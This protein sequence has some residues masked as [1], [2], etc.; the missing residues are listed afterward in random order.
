MHGIRRRKAHKATPTRKTFELRLASHPRNV[1]RV[2]AFLL[3]VNRQARLD[4]GTMYRLLVACTEAVNNAI[5]HGN[6]ADPEKVV[7]VT[8]RLAR[9]CLTLRVKDQ[10]P[11]FD[12][13][14]LPS[15]LEEQNLMRESGR[16]VFLMRSLM[17]EVRFERL[18]RGSVVQM[19]ICLER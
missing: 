6:K 18:K 9:R 13:S 3:K 11:G 1:G 8:C 16:G 5:L 14:K 19:R 10:G 2:E 12:A 17:D 7:L 15:P 4:D